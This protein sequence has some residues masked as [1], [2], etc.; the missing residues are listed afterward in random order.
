METGD[1]VYHK[2]LGKGVLIDTYKDNAIVR[3]LD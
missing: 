2:L 1:M 3:F